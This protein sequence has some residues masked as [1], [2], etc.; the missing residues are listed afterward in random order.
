MNTNQPNDLEQLIRMCGEEWVIDCFHPKD[1]SIMHLR[2]ALDAATAEAKQRGLALD[3]SEGSLIASY[4][5]HSAQVNAFLQA[6]GTTR[7]PVMLVMVWRIFQG[8]QISRVSMQYDEA[9]AVFRLEIVLHNSPYDTQEE[10]YES[11]DIGDAVLLRHFGIMTM[12]N[13]P[14][15]DGFYALKLG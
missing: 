7:N 12:D 10:I 14:I 11:T 5:K 6:L 2:Q 13:K 9:Q 15:F 3:F 8:Y 1:E 4:E